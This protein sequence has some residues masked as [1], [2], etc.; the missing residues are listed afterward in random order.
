MI[1]RPPSRPIA[2]I[3]SARAVPRPPGDGQSAGGYENQKITRNAVIEAKLVKIPLKDY[4]LINKVTDNDLSPY[5]SLAIDANVPEAEWNV[6]NHT[7]LASLGIAADG[8]V[9]Y[10]VTNNTLVYSITAGEVT[11]CLLYTSPSPRDS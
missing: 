11:T 6:D 4:G 7:S 9:I 5:G 10:P 2:W 3:N 1:N 8:V